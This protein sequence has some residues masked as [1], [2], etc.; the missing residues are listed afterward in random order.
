MM[1]IAI[2]AMPLASVNSKPNEAFHPHHNSNNTQP[3]LSPQPYTVDQVIHNVGN[4]ATTVDNWGYMGGYWPYGLPSGEW[5]RGSGHS[6]LAEALYWM[7]V[8]DS[9]GDTLVADAYDDFQALPTDSSADPYY[10]LLSTDTT[11]YLGYD[12]TD[13]IGSGVGS[14]A[15]GWRIWDPVASS[16][17]YNQ[18][19]NTLSAS[20]FPAG[21]TSLQE[22]HYRFGDAASGVPLLGL[23]MTQTVMQWNYC[24]NEDFYYVV[25]EIT[26]NS[27]VDYNNFI[28]GLYM[29]MDVGGPDGSGEN[30]RLQDMVG[31]DS[32]GQ[33]AWIYDNL[34][35]DPGWGA[36]LQT[37]F[38]GTKLLQTPDNIGT[39]SF[40][41][42]D[43]SF[44]PQD[45][46]GRYVM[47]SSGQFDV[48]HPPTDQVYIQCVGGINL[49]AGRTVRV[50]Y[51]VVAGQ[52]EAELRDNADLAEQLF[53]AN[54]VGPKPP[55][56]PT[57]KIRPGDEK[58]YLSWNDT[59]EF[60][61]DPFSG[62]Q[63]FVGYKLYRSENKG[64]T[65]GI[66]D[67][68][69]GNNCLTVDY[70]TVARFSAFNP[71]DPIQHS[72][73]DTGLYNG[74]E[75]WYCLAAFDTGDSVAG[76]DAL[77]SGFGSPEVNPHIVAVSPTPDP[78]GYY[79]AASTVIH[80]YIGVALPSDGNIFPQIFDPLALTGNNFRVV[81]ED[82]PEVTYWHVLN[83]ATG[84]TVLAGQSRTVGDPDLYEIGGGLRVVVRDGDHEPRGWGQSALGGPDTNLVM[85]SWYG[86][87][88][89][90]VTADPSDVFGNE[91]FRSVFE[92]RYTGDSTRANGLLDGFDGTDYVY[93]V[94]FELWNVTANERVSMVVYDFF[95]DGVWDPY[96][97]L[98]IVNYPYDSVT[99]VTPFAFP[100]YYS[101]LIGF[102]D[103]VYNPSIGDVFTIESAP[104]NSPGDEF[105]FSVDGIDAADA[106]DDLKDVKVV[107]D[108]YIAQYSAKVETAEGESALEFQNIPTE[109][110]IR[111]YT[112]SGDLVQTLNHTDGTGSERWNL[113]SGSQQQIASG[114]Y[115]FH[116]ESPFGNRIGRFAVIK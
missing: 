59:A 47:M 6:Y 50:V 108:P 99:S 115:I 38:M 103:A 113:L 64:K 92:F 2:F 85:G 35:E 30:G 93:W 83:D 79:G 39:T 112:M 13:T 54:Y 17:V 57:L 100:E 18:V 104:L 88:L 34:G 44:I 114:I 23:E 1:A 81:F 9:T 65:W 86:P 33:L 61:V 37:G 12:P 90:A 7:G 41:T 75:Y 46:E 62:L 53:L 10:I 40:R 58:N 69:T 16:Y 45:D 76:V 56:S 26:N 105:L 49:T 71:G 91:H 97:L 107:P 31:Y 80:N 8:V 51:A 3:V 110:T 27:S 43:W 98:G 19:Y 84:D 82:A 60:S 25:L 106:S 4:I 95:G 20:Y 72:F 101:W 68:T 24:Y 22:S 55:I 78:A 48:S 29:D 73:V 5:P 67:Y 63:D 14:P 11:R 87:A 28:F 66:V 77:Q 96:D 70:S 52:T 89:P 36:G 74:V 111:I 102:D 116:V 32:A 21:P 42:D 109:C 15:N 94:P